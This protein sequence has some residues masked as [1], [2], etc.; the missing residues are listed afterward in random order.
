[1][2]PLF[3]SLFVNVIVESH[4]SFIG[5][6]SADLDE[7]TVEISRDGFPIR[8]RFEEID[9]PERNQPFAEQAK[10][11]NANMITGKTVDVNQG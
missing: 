4:L 10:A 2:L 1:M 3:L 9:Y 7:V 11:L 6:C 5:Y 8:I